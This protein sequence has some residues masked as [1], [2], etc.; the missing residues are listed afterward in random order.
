MASRRDQ[1]VILRRLYAASIVIAQQLKEHNKRA[2]HAERTAAWALVVIA[3]ML[4][5]IVIRVYL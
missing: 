1:V 2:L 4:A 5:L 3:A